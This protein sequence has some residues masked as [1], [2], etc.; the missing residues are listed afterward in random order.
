MLALLAGCQTPAA[1][2]PTLKVPA[3]PAFEVAK[4]AENKPLATSLAV[5][6]PA[7]ASV[8]AALQ[9]AKP[10]RKTTASLSTETDFFVREASSVKRKTLADVPKE[11]VAVSKEATDKLLVGPVRKSARRVANLTRKP[12]YLERLQIRKDKYE[13]IITRHAK[14]AGVP[15]Q[16]AMAIVQIESSF[17]VKAKGAAGEVGL[18]QVKPRTARGMGYKG[19]VNALYDPEVNIRYGM[20]YLAEARRRGGG[21]TCGTILKYNAGHYAKR[22]NPISARY[23]QKVKK[24]M[25]KN[26]SL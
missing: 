10:E 25:A 22:M 4:T 3:L 24:V 9:A 7:P 14:A 2:L 20:K 23:C 18:M 12:N 16:L 19:S 11:I 6:T 5:P 21:T 26:A 15:V 1:T 8:R 13:P 17:R